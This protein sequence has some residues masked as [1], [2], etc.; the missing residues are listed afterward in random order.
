MASDPSSADALPTLSTQAERLKWARER[1]F[2]SPREAA[3]FHDWNENTYK[4][5]EGGI[6]GQ[7]GL[8]LDDLRK[9]AQAFQVPA[10]WLAGIAAP[11]SSGPPSAESSD[12]TRQ[13]ALATQLRASN[14]QA[15]DLHLA[16]FGL[17]ES[18]R[19]TVDIPEYDVRLSAGGGTLGD[20]DT[21]KGSWRFPRGY[22]ARELRAN[23]NS[24]HI[25]EVIGDSME[26]KLV[27]GD[28]IVVDQ[29]DT[30]P[31]PP[32]IFALWDGYGLVV[33]NLQRVHKPDPA[34]LLLISENPKYP[35]Y[36]VYFED[37]NIIGR[38]VSCVRKM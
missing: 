15:N 1:R 30:N 22:V 6:R 13:N 12:V 3:R 36:E 8:K 33:K 24:L 25:V 38:V 31:T 27:P 23:A 26:P 19:A 17:D 14:P 2:R 4:S 28:R 29:N 5:H 9:Y 34:K 18:P 10:D 21:L 20:G 35:P 16:D 32:G 37:I 7:G 11:K